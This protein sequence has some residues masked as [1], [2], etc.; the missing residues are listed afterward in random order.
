MLLL[1]S[2][3]CIFLAA[4]ATVGVS[5]SFYVEIGKNTK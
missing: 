4:K 1:I 2:Q 5:D 3:K